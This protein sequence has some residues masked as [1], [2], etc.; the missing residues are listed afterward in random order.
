MNNVA[1]DP[2]SA[3]VLLRFADLA[4]RVGAPIEVGDVGPGKRRL[5]PVLGGTFVSRDWSARV[6]EG[7]ADFQLVVNDHMAQLE[8]RY[9]VE[10]DAGD[11]I[12]V[13]NDAVRTA[14]PDVMAR[15]MRGEQ[16]DPVDVYFRSVPRFEVAAPALRWMMERMF[17]GTGQRHPDQVVMRFWQ[18]A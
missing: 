8:A 14:A 16:V 18:L 5:I 1:L 4:V 15:L 7:G 17:V 10:T 6:L 9:V 2:L 11:R 3:P 12:F 13:K